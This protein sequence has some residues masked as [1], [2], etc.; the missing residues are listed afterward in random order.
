MVLKGETGSRRAVSLNGP[1]V[2]A[3][4]TLLAY[5]GVVAVSYA[6]Q[7]SPSAE[8]SPSPAPSASATPK[9][10]GGVSEGNIPTSAF[11]F[12]SKGG[13][14]D[15]KSDSL[16]LDYKAK[17]V[18]FTGNVHASQSGTE[19]TSDTLRIIYG[20]NFRDIQKV[21]ADGDVKITQG[22]RSATSDH[23][24]LDQTTRTV[25]MTGNP[26]IHDGPDQITG[27]R[28]LV[29]LDSQKSVVEGARAVIF[30]RSKES[31]DN[32]VSNDHAAGQGH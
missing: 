15:I 6:Q 27:T 29:Y 31:R 19:L 1:A 21:L 10:A 24:V 20:D 8:P 32:K 5:F 26:V 12:T 11:S 16:S 9:A 7:P 30:P 23:A 25:E 3:L 14:I 4:A 28:V 2:F 17:T 13:P 22:G 18:V